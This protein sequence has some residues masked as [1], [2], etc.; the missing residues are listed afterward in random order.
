MIEVRE[1]DDG[2]LAGM[3]SLQR[4]V[5][6][7]SVLGALGTDVVAR[8]LAAQLAEEQVV[9]LV[10][11][12]EGRLVGYLIGGRFGGATSAFVR[13]NLGLLVR[14]VLRH[15]AALVR[16]GGGVAVKVAVAAVARPRRGAE[17]PDRVPP[18]SFGIL[19]VAVEA[20]SRRRGVGRALLAEAERIARSRGFERLH[21]TVDSRARGASAFYGSLGWLRIDPDTDHATRWL[22][23][24][25]L[26]S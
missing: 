23:G 20:G 10:A 1:H 12:D 7:D 16:R 9:G 15:P 24:K 26:R 25:D 14:R 4:R 3:A 18:R 13:A 17:R 5:A 8:F 6:P 19:A 2:D 11:E 22:M 21:L